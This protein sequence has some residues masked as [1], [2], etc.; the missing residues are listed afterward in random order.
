M[1]TERAQ[2]LAAALLANTSN[3]SEVY[4]LHLSAHG[5]PFAAMVVVS[6]DCLTWHRTMFA[7]VERMLKQHGLV[8]Q[9]QGFTRDMRA[10]FVWF[11]SPAVALIPFE[12][13]NSA[14]S[15]SPSH[16]VA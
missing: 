14:Q 2:D 9:L 3:R 1:N 11:E 13:G 16:E 8:S 5:K 10:V 6:L 12:T 15:C 4:E 7:V